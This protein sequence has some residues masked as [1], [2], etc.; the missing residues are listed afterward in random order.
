VVRLRDSWNAVICGAGIAGI[1]AAYFLAVRHR[2]QVLLVDERPPL[3]LTSDKS[4]ECYRNWWPGPGRALV[5]LMDRSIDLL[6][7]LSD[8]TG[9]A[10]HLNRRG[11]LYV[12]ADPDRVSALRQE[13]AAI[14]ALGAGPLRVHPGSH[15]YLPAPA[16]GYHDQP[17]GA[18]LIL[19]PSLIRAHFPYLTP[20]AIAALHVRRAGWF[21]AQ[22]LGMFLLDQAR[23]QGVELAPDRVVGVETRGGAVQGVRLASGRRAHTACFVNAAG[24][25]FKEVGRMA[26]LDLPVTAELHLK[27]AL[28]D[29][30]GVVPRN[31]PLLIWTD[32]QRLEWT[33]EERALLAEDEASRLLLEPLPAGAH[34]RPEGGPGSQMLLLLW[35]YRH[36]GET[37]PGPL[38]WPPPL[39]PQFPEL[40]LRGLSAMIPGLRAYFER[41]PRPRLDGGYYI[42]SP[43]NRLLAGPTPVSGYYL[44]GALSGYGLMA[45][46]AAGELLAAWIL[47]QALPPYAPAFALARYEDPRYLRLLQEWV[48]T[49]QL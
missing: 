35:E 37:Y 49:G 16:S 45:A 18:D 8:L 23:S 17:G 25:F 43:E 10:F 1:S 22:Q 24:P 5:A 6:E 13:A 38:P 20:K 47:E 34:T 46:L 3:S 12:T 41:L 44:I 31:A 42:K 19:D 27:T 39:D 40:A 21:S 15:A 29:A 26:G 48:D 14:S 7:E 36:P 9:D 2:W 32:P 28:D 11:Y 33:E 4:T 30:L